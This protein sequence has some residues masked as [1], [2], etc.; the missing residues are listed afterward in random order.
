MSIE[1][2]RK[3]LPLDLAR[4]V[5]GYAW[6]Q[7]HLGLSPSDVFRLEAANKKSFYLKIA[8]RQPGF[9]LLREKNILDWLKNRL[10]VPEVL[11]FAETERAD[12]LLLSEIDGAPASDDSLRKDARRIVEQL[13]NALKNIH[14]LSIADC[15]F[16]QRLERKIERAR[17]RM[18][19]GLV[20]EADFDEERQGRPV[21]ELFG[22][23]IATRPTNEDLVFTHGDYCAPNVIFKNGR[24]SGFVDLGNAGIADR[25]QDLALLSRSVGYNFG[26]EWEESVFEIYGVEPDRKKINFYKLLD[27]FF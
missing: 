27:E 1:N 18:L 19:N 3:N 11:L 15:P 21:E 20:D 12:Y 22:E 4:A 10:P 2:V 6:R 16:D 13:T 9:S 25:F 5:S 17:Q 24:P 8:A 14:A 7:I 23:L 26:D